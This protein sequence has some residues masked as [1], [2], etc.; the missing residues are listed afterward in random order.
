MTYNRINNLTGW[1]VFALSLLVYLLTVAPTASFWD[2]GEF[3]AC[4]NELEVTHPPGAPLFLLMGRIFAMLSFGDVT[5]VAS[6]INFMSALASAFTALFT[7]WTVTMLARKGLAGKEMDETYKTVAGMAAG[8]VAGFACAFADSVWFNAVEAEVYALSSFFT[9]IVVWLIFK[10]EARADEPDHLRWIVLIA[11]LMG[12]SIGVHLLNLLTIPALALIYYFRKF[13]PTPLGFVITM[14]ISVAILFVIQYGII[15]YQFSLAWAFERFFTG[16]MQRDGSVDGGLGLPMGTGSTVLALLIG[17]GLVGLLI[18]SHRQRRVTLNTAVLALTVIL[19]GFSSYGMIFIRS[20]VNPP[21]DMN[22]PENILTFLSYMRREQYGDRPLLRGPLYHAQVERDAQGYPKTKLKG[23]KYIILDG[24]GR[25][26]EDAP[27]Y[28]YIYRQQDVVWFPRMYTP[29]R[30]RSGPFG[31]INYVKRKGSDPQSPYDDKPS[32]GENMRFF[33]DY[34]VQHMY[35]RYFMWNFVGR[36]SDEQESRWESGLEVFD[37][38][39]FTPDKMTNKGKNHY[40]FL[41]LFLGMLGLIWQIIYRRND[42]AVIGMLFFFTGLAIVIY[43][44]QYPAQ[45]RERDYSYAGSF[46]TFAMW[47]GMGVL[48]LADMLYRTL[49]RWSAWVAGVV[50]LLAPGLM[51]AE[52]WDDHTR[53][54]RYIDIEFAKNLLDSC[55]PNAILFTGG[56]ND[57]FPLWYVQEVEGYRTDIRVVN[58]ELLISDWYIDQMKQRKND[59]EPLPIGMDKRDYAGERNILI[60]GYASR[61][62]VLPADTAA[63][64]R[65]GVLSDEELSWVDGDMVW[66]FKAQGS[67]RNPYIL[68]KDSVIIDILRNVARDGWQRPVYFANTMPAANYLDLEDWF[69]M[70]GMA[71]RVVPVRR[72][73]RTPNDL[74]SGWVAQDLMYRNLT[75][76]FR[77]SGLDDPG[78]Y[79]DEHI[80]GVI[81]GNYRNVFFRLANTYAEQAY[82]VYLANRQIEAQLAAGDATPG[83]DAMLAAGRARADSL[84]SKIR[85]LMQF[86]DA[87]IPAQVIVKPIALTLSEAQMYSRAGMKDEA[88]NIVEATVGRALEEV[89]ASAE[90]GV[91]LNPQAMNVRACLFA[92][93]FYKSNRMTD[94]A[95]SVAARLDSV[96]GQRWGQMILQDQQQP[97]GGQ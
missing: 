58:L 53:R 44:N 32:V 64:R 96:S 56:D 24:D 89:A 37:Q 22:N 3:I 46:Q 51:L 29:D 59:S 76:T 20:N 67:S 39:R 79:F 86:A 78:V 62:I 5:R 80:R 82:N 61:D 19:I 8:V 94:A 54:G 42:A 21:I 45:P 68:R 69:R 17:G 52:N 74:Y 43:L 27:S 71:Y 55:A 4:S 28:E 13:K 77:Y 84:R 91:P 47:I 72:S 36:E 60:Q 18:Y 35:L 41:P 88:V 33:F 70:E 25:Y 1:A 14:L 7:C 26:V 48:F 65:H 40:Y 38:S 57:T 12:L 87:K 50:C 11:Y 10:W 97:S 16:T 66:A 85:E 6:M 49:R 83:L 23:T 31:Y 95:A 90:A 75:E 63:L 2:C 34:Q 30:Y 81:V 9:A 73:E 92:I 93:Q 15:Q